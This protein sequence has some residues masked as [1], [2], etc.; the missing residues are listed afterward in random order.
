VLTLLLLPAVFGVVGIID[1]ATDPEL[2]EYETRCYGEDG[3]L[4]NSVSHYEEEP[5]GEVEE[6]EC[7]N[8]LTLH[9]ETLNE[10]LD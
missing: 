3:S 1:N 7:A 2:P 9:Y 6:W 4:T 10:N 8:T 5:P